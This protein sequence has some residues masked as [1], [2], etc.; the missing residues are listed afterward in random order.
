MAAVPADGLTSAVTNPLVPQEVSVP[1]VVR[2]PDSFMAGEIHAHVEVWDRLTR[3]LPNRAELMGWITNR[4][5]AKEY[6]AAFFG[7][8]CWYRIQ[9]GHSR[10]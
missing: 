1:L 2:D 4:V 6:F 8:I 7:R 5:S 9:L 3:D 10:A